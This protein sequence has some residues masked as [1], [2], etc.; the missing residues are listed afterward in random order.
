MNLE[1]EDVFTQVNNLCVTSIYLK[2]VYKTIIWKTKKDMGR[3]H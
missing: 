1:T 2:N 3:L